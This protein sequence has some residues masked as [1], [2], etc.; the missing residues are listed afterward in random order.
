MRRSSKRR[1]KRILQSPLDKS[2]AVFT[3][4]GTLGVILLSTVQPSSAWLWLALAVA[5]V[6]LTWLTIRLYGVASTFE[7]S[8]FDQIDFAESRERVLIRVL[9]GLLNGEKAQP[10]FVH[11]APMNKEVLAVCR[12]LRESGF[13]TIYGGPGEGKSMTAYHAAYKLY[14]DENYSPYLL[15]VDMLTNKSFSE[16]RGELLAQ[17]DSL[18]S[19]RKLIVIDDGHKLACRIDLNQLMRNE[20]P[21]EQLRVIWVETEFYQ[22]T[23]TQRPP[24]QIQIDFSGFADELVRNLYRRQDVI[25]EFALRGQI[26]GLDEAI[27]KTAT[28]QIRDA[29]HF[30]FV[31][32]Q[33]EKRVEEEI[34]KLDYA[35]TLALLLIS[36]HTVLSGEQE[37]STAA[38]MNIVARLG[39]GWL[40]DG[41]R[42]RSLTDIV[43]SLQEHRLESPPDKQMI[44]RMPFIRL[45]NKS[46]NDR[47]YVASLHYNSARE[48]VRAALLKTMIADDLLA[49]LR[50][51]LTSDYRHCAYISV[52]LRSIGSQQRA[53]AFVRANE[54]WFV[55][56]LSSPEPDIIHAYPTLLQT[57]SR[58]DPQVCRNIVDA[59]DVNHIAEKVSAV[60]VGKVQSLADLLRALGGR[61]D[62]VVEKVAWQN[63][64]SSL[65]SAD[66]DQLSQLASLLSALGDHRDLLV[67]RV[68][69]SDLGSSLS[70]SKVSHFQQIAALLNALGSRRTEFV[71]LV[72]WTTI[73][74]KIRD[75]AGLQD[76][77]SVGQLLLALRGDRP[78]LLKE[79]RKD[80][81][82]VR[83]ASEIS[84]APADKFEQIA[85]FLR[86]L[87]QPL[88]IDIS[89]LVRTANECSGDSLKGLTMLMSTLDED[90]RAGLLQAVDW[91]QLCLR[92]PIRAGM[93]RALGS[94]LENTRNKC[95]VCA[96]FAD[97][98]KVREH[99][100]ANLGL[101]L[102]AVRQ[103]YALARESGSFYGGVSKL[104]YNCCQIDKTL[105]FQI[106]E[107]TIGAAVRYFSILPASYRY[108]G[109]LIDAFYE[110]HPD[111]ARI[112]VENA[113]TSGRIITS[114]NMHDW[115]ERTAEVTRLVR[116][117]Y[118]ASPAGWAKML[119]RITASL[120]E[121]YL[122]SV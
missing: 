110:V 13:V 84:K 115:N 34:S 94:C 11:V 23:I 30:A 58:F 3:I 57:L 37:L 79:L 18:R 66:P 2:A 14:R 8:Y 61:R 114:L 36:A 93:L 80:D 111:A 76:L 101:I 121:V 4:F 15:R 85:G 20:V 116:A 72:D 12:T 71:A 62:M 109:D 49:S 47:G 21:E 55:D 91:T 31:A 59:L 98:A 1:L 87:G 17:L 33:G 75:A 25:F 97:C 29:W 44:Q 67:E 113:K 52:L 89:P 112:F 90:C 122:E 16:L 9:Y 68:V 74:G 50:S 32:S 92:C 63:L 108:V 95:E 73:A 65:S 40:A 82:L 88:S 41:L 46:A 35:E 102:H 7:A 24:S 60:D 48:I 83:L 27:S 99:L 106:V 120:K 100:K 81:G 54:K 64:A 78:L 70:N 5:L 69:W 107:Q 42:R 104:V 10:E 28:G 39:F 6:C 103:S 86:S 38:L 45:Y 26:E 43:R 96:D 51:L 119:I 105:A 77:Q 56:F 19:R 117:I 53:I 22:E 118:R